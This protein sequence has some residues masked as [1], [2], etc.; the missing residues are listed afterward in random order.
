[1]GLL[2][3]TALDRLLAE[4]CTACTAPAHQVKKLLFRTYVD[5]KL[6]I[7]GGEPNGP[8]T[9]AY[10]GETFLDGVFDV[11]CVECKHVLFQADVCPRCHRE[12]ALPS[13]LETENR[14]SV[15]K[16]C[17]RCG[18]ADLKYVAMVPARV[19]YAGVRAEKAKTATDLFDP[20]FHGIRVDCGACGPLDGVEGKC[21]LCDAPGPI[22]K[23]PT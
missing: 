15:P 4:G 6:P 16:E 10:K 8:I 20:G 22:R 11:S 9:W 18:I 23:R 12:G 21:P 1:M 3:A 17:P 19:V 7:A 2:D 5:A 14:L 13:I